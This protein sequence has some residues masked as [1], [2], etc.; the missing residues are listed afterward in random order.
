MTTVTE[1]H[2]QATFQAVAATTKYLA[3][4]GDRDCCGFAWVTI[5]DVKLNTKQ[6]KEFAA[7]GFRKGYGKGAGIQ[8]WNPSG[9]HT[10]SIT[11]KEVGAEAYAKVFEAAGFKAYAGSRM[12]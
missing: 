3:Q 1:L 12:D 6:G 8:L 4:H 10:Q 11:A 2:Q 9:H 5:F 7:L